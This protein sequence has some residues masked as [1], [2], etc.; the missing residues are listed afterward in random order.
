MQSKDPSLWERVSPLS[1]PASPRCCQSLTARPDRAFFGVLQKP[2][3]H[4]V[5]TRRD[6]RKSSTQDLELPVTLDELHVEVV[7]S[8]HVVRPTASEGTGWSHA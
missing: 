2:A 6:V 3:Q 4:A 1:W 5:P 8:C 7:T